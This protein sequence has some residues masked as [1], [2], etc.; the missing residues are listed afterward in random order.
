M[1]EFNPKIKP[2]FIAKSISETSGIV[3]RE[4]EKKIIL[5]ERSES[6]DIGCD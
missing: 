6:P 4:Y 1:L 2:A 5:T 3:V